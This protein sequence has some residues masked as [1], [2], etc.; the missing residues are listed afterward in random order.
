[1]SIVLDI[2]FIPVVEWPRMLIKL[3]NAL[4]VIAFALLL[5]LTLIL[6]ATEPWWIDR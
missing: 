3:I 1:M 5:G 2:E 6:S 4:I